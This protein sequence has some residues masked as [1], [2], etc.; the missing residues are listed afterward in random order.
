[1]SVAEHIVARVAHLKAEQLRWDG[2]RQQASAQ[3][4]EHANREPAAEADAGSTASLDASDEQEQLR[5]Q[6]TSALAHLH[7]IAAELAQIRDALQASS[8]QQELRDKELYDKKDSERLESL[9]KEEQE[10]KDALAKQEY[11][12]QEALA[13]QGHDKQEAFPNAE[14]DKP[15]SPGPAQSAGDFV[16][17][18][19]AECQYVLDEIAAEWEY[20]DQEIAKEMQYN[21][22]QAFEA[23]AEA[24]FEVGMALANPVSQNEGKQFLEA[25]RQELANFIADEVFQSA[26][27][28]HKQMWLG[29]KFNEQLRAEGEEFGGRKDDLGIR[30][31]VQ[32]GL[33]ELHG[34]L[35]EAVRT[36]REMEARVNAWADTQRATHAKTQARLESAGYAPEVL[37]QKTQQL[38]AIAKKQEQD[39][40]ADAA[41]D[42]QRVWERTEVELRAIEAERRELAERQDAEMRRKLEAEALENLRQL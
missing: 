3:L 23:V 31:L 15:Q 37:E 22:S 20:V 28:D 8:Q 21:V 33:A 27:A 39:Y 42:L 12:K 38:D 1:M 13:K 19:A 2:L 29:H 18:I 11:E 30:K 34:S 32:D 16:A 9:V 10:K 36:E 41:R 14:R 26:P 35:L 7:D 40:R 6:L 4:L 24:G 17:A 25:R 5:S